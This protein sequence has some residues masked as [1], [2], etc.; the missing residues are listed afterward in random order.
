MREPIDII[1]QAH[2][3]GMEDALYEGKEAYRL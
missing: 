3:S 1:S 2:L